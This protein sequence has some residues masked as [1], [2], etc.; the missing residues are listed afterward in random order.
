MKRTTTTA[1]AL[2]SAVTLTLTACGREET[3]AGGEAQSEAISGG[4]A[5]GTIEVWAMGAEGEKLEAFSAAFEKENPDA[6]VKVTIV[7]WD[8]AHD[9]LS[10]A[11]TA[12][13]NR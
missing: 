11:I 3:S 9:K 10:S 7:P 13:D 8:G 1:V 5:E 6:D 12:G 2:L 4:K